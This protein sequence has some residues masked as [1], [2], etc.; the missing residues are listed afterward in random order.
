MAN[1]NFSE[2]ELES[3][4]NSLDGIQKAAPQPFLYTRLMA[5]MQRADDNAWGRVLQI[6]SKPAFSLGLIFV[7]LMINGYILF[8][9]FN[10]SAEPAEESTQA[11]ALEYTSL[12]S[13]FYDNNE[14]TP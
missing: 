4:L 2:Q 13:P 7:F 8:N 1:K 14:E 11:L 9:Q 12:T 3:I 10:D 6:V 5:R